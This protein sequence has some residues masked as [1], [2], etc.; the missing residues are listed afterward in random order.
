MSEF[1]CN[2]IQSSKC[3]DC[4]FYSDMPLTNPACMS[5]N[6]VEVLNK[7]DNYR[8]RDLTLK[9]KTSC[10]EKEREAE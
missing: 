1:I 2:Y 9:R 7:K 4:H 5:C 6:H 3:K 8:K 10:R